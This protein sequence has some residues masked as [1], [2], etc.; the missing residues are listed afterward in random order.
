MS[1]QQPYLIDT[2]PSQS[3]NS[4]YICHFLH[5]RLLISISALGFVRYEAKCSYTF[6]LHQTEIK[7]DWGV[8]RCFRYTVIYSKCIFCLFLFDYFSR[9]I[10]GDQ[11]SKPFHEIT[12]I[13]P[14]LITLQLFLNQFPYK[15]CLFS[16]FFFYSGFSYRLVWKV[17]KV[18]KD[19]AREVSKAPQ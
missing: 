17:F 7:M 18:L 15:R 11:K 1:P 2:Q 12:T 10:Q 14:R 16:S 6:C 3:D 5:L 4:G 9:Y 13:V 19:L 8:F